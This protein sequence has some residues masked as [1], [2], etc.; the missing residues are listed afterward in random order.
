MLDLDALHRHVKVL[1]KGDDAERRQAVHSL[2]E[3]EE[4]DWSA[5]PAPV[6]Q[7]LVESLRHE[8]GRETTQPLVRREIVTALGKIGPRSAPAVPE[9]IELPA[10]LLLIAK[11]TAPAVLAGVNDWPRAGVPLLRGSGE[12]HP[13]T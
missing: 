12:R 10:K 3:I 8:F 4:Q 11:S 6:V 5:A 2:N 1:Q 9:L 7:S 13:Q